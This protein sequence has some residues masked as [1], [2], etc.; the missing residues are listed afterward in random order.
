M[1]S[2]LF[3]SKSN[4]PISDITEFLNT[5]DTPMLSVAAGEDLD[6]EFILDE[7]LAAI[8]SFPNS[9]WA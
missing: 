7:V 1:P 5:I 4:M 6:K 2:C 3:T 9:N 8:K